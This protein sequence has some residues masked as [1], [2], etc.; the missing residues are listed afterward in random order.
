MLTELIMI[1]VT[2]IILAMRLF[3]RVYILGALH[4]DDWWI[5]MAMCIL[6]AL[7][8][9]HGVGMYPFPM[10]GSLR[11]TNWRNKGV[12]YGIGK[13]IYDI[14]ISDSNVALTVS[15]IS[16]P[17]VKSLTNQLNLDR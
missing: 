14:S 3:T 10:R 12:K 16:L 8:A 1:A 7:T 2:L 9:V 5:M 6:I 4:S 15:R 13:H 11:T 17:S